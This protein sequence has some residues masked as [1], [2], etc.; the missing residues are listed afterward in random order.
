MIFYQAWWISWSCFVGLF[1]A[2]ISRG[3][4][5]REVII[6]TMIAPIAYCILWF[7]IWGG[8]GQRQAR[9]AE[10]LEVLGSTQF[11]NP[12][13]FKVSGSKICYNVP[14]ESLYNE[15]NDEI[16]TNHLVGIT[17]VCKFDPDDSLQS[18]FNVLASFSFPDSF[19]TGMGPTLT[20]IFVI[21]L[22]IYFAT[23]SDSGSLIVD[24]LA[25]NGR[26]N[27]HWIQRLFWALTEGAVATALLGAGGSD[28]LNALQA[29]SIIAGL[30]FV[31]FLIFI[32]QSISV[33]CERAEASES[34][35]FKHPEQSEFSMPVYGGIFN[36][37]EYICSFGKVHP[38]RVQ[39]GMDLPTRSQVWEFLRGI[40][41]PFWS[42][43]QVLSEVYPKNRPNNL[44]AAGIY[45]LLYVT[46]I[47]LFIL[48]APFPG[49]VGWA[50][51]TFFCTG[52]LLTTIRL[53]FRGR[54]NVRGNFLLGDVLASTF[55]WPQVLVQMRQHVQECGGAT[56]KVKDDDEADDGVL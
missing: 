43:F 52:C 16:F 3:R 14:Q 45:G 32:V 24:Y 20:V 25:S 13:E 23:S 47:V 26:A 28:A 41:V 21:A 7:S 1:V 42:L 51:T 53:G 55:M 50:W 5:V 10:E 15:T 36:V 6:Y 8:I 22:A 35:T 12:D 46:W 9:Q 29:A 34:R 39:K 33:M 2:R 19:S 31:I 49:I 37:C 48:S 56:T 40:V 30:P 11:G 27:H 44:L 4:T 18:A 38:D 17:P 54:Y